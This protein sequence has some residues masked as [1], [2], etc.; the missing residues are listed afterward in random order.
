MHSHPSATITKYHFGKLSYGA[1]N[2]GSTTVGNAVKGFECT[3]M[4][5]LN[6]PTNPMFLLV[7]S[8][9]FHQILQIRSHF[10]SVKSITIV[11][12]T[13]YLSVAG[14]SIVTQ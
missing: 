13:L 5:R 2:K 4:F 6:P 8:H 1:W 11:Q 10:L 9:Y 14:L 7:S 12:S 3:A